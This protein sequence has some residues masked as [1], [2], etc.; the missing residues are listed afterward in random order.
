MKIKN[1][2]R[3]VVMLITVS[4][5]LGGNILAYGETAGNAADTEFSLKVIEPLKAGET[6]TVNLVVNKDLHM[7]SWFFNIQFNDE[8]VELVLEKDTFGE[9]DFIVY[10]VPGFKA[11]NYLEK[12]KKAK[13]AGAYTQTDEKSKVPSGTVFAS[14][15][16][17]AKVDLSVGD[18]AATLLEGNFTDDAEGISKK[19]TDG[20]ECVVQESKSVTP[21]YEYDASSNPIIPEEVWMALLKGN[22]EKDVVITADHGILFVFAQGTMADMEEQEEYNFG[23]EV[24]TDFDSAGVPGAV[25]KTDFVAKITCSFSGQLPAGTSVKI[26]LGTTYA[27]KELSYF[28]LKDDNTL[29]EE[30]KV[31]ADSDG[32]ILVKPVTGS[33][34]ILTKETETEIETGMLGDV[35]NSETITTDDALLI[36]QHVAGITELKGVSLNNADVNKDTNITTDDAL[37]VL[38]VAAGLKDGFE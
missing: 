23:T 12:E 24:I 14:F 22:K 32:C 17:K 19:I 11:C 21:L 10:D 28:L 3:I 2:K 5:V 8:K 27:D 1:L 31:T 33:K 29:G 7:N 25:E 26:P 6:A 9:Y 30:Q 18:V 13:I 37:E 38:R 15:K 35:D 36:L 16:I 20:V 4:L 34:Y